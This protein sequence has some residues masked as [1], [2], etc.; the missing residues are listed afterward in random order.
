M[1]RP[2]CSL[3]GDGAFVKCCERGWHGLLG[4]VLAGKIYEVWTES[5]NIK[6]LKLQQIPIPEE[7]E[8]AVDSF[9]GKKSSVVTSFF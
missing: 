8:N 7:V 5:I 2:I 3:V 4:N 9:G 6:R 1:M